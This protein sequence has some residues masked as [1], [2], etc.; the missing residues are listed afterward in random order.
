M[1]YRIVFTLA[2]ALMLGG[3]V[4]Y[5]AEAQERYPMVNIAP[6]S[7]GLLWAAVASVDTW[8]DSVAEAPA[9]PPQIFM[10]DDLED[11]LARGDNSCKVYVTR[12]YL[13]DVKRVLRT[14]TRM[15]RRGVLRELW[16]VMAHERGH[17]LGLSHAKDNGIMD[18]TRCLCI[19]P[20]AATAWAMSL[21]PKPIDRRPR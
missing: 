18:V 8:W 19:A 6:S 11:N 12:A 21:T 4:C 15:E 1:Y 7:D 10:Y 9:C 5:D 20:G 3:F 2:V 17:N 16:D 13:K 14:G